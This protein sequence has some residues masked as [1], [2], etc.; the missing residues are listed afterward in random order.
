[1][2]KVFGKLAPWKAAGS[3]GVQGSW[4]ENFTSLHGRIVNQISEG[5]TELIPKH[6]RKGNVM[7]TDNMTAM[8]S[9]SINKHMEEQNII[10]WGQKG[11]ERKSR[12][13]NDQLI[14]R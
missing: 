9:E 13:T 14:Y 10:P 7:Q 4:V 12:E 8:I 5:R 3:D 6:P 2:K 1:M 11:C